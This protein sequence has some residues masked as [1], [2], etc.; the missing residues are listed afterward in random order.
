M[1][2]AHPGDLDVYDVAWLA[3][4]A[5]RATQAAVAA[6]VEGGRVRVADPDGELQVARRGA[7]HPVEAAVL[8]ALGVRAHR[9][10]ETLVFLVRA[11]PRLAAVE[12]AARPRRGSAAGLAAAV[13]RKRPARVTR[14]GR[15]ALRQSRRPGNAGLLVS[16]AVRAVALHGLVQVPAGLPAALAEAPPPRWSFTRRPPVDSDVARVYAGN[17]GAF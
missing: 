13:R 5:R 7:A 10:T 11:D 14:S 1:T 2:T 4:G 8:D 3:G 17:F 16:D 6:L 15:R 9:G 12:E